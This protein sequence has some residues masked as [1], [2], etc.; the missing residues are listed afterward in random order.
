MQAF[1]LASLTEKKLMVSRKLLKNKFAVSPVV[2]TLLMLA[3]TVILAA[4]YSSTAFNNEPV[5]SAPK[6]S[7]E[8]LENSTATNNVPASI[9]L[10]HLG[11][12][13]V[14]FGDS[15]ITQVKASLNGAESVLIDATSLGDMSIGDTKLLPL[16]DFNGNNAFGKGPVSG[17]TVNIKIIDV[18]TRQMITNT[19][20]KF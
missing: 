14:S 12:D 18:K 4:I 20:V 1:C 10:T 13:Q 7:I 8:I 3:I 16:A 15:N 17:D 2:G 19:D 9:K 11:G 6:G 5:Q